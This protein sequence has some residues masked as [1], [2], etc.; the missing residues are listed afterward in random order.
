MTIKWFLV[1]MFEKE[2]ITRHH[3]MMT[4][5]TIKSYDLMNNKFNINV[6]DY[7]LLQGIVSCIK[8]CS[9]KEISQLH[10]DDIYGRLLSIQ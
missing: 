4:D 3:I 8:K 9:E 6:N 10:T 1:N 7:L 5:G 2:I